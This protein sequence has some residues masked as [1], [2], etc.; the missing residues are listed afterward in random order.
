MTLNKL[1]RTPEQESTADKSLKAFL[2]LMI[3]LNSLVILM[4]S[5]KGCH[6]VYARR[7]KRKQREQQKVEM[8]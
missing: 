2:F 6:N 7:Q 8:L 1:L 3:G 5:F 4:I